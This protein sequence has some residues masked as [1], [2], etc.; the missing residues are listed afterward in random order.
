MSDAEI[1]GTAAQIAQGLDGAAPRRTSVT[2][3]ELFHMAPLSLGG[4]V[5][6][7]AL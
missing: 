7:M 3:A 4:A 5:G 2:V 6:T 1:E